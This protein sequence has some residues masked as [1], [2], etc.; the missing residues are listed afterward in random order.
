MQI[1]NLMYQKR[2]CQNNIN[3][4]L[5]RITTALLKQAELYQYTPI[6]HTFT[7]HQNKAFIF[8]HFFSLI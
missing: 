4:Q 1:E 5:N 7:D 6:L 8:S 2:S 3:Q